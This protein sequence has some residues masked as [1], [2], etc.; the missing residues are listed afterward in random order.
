MTRTRERASNHRMDGDAINLAR[1]A[2]RSPGKKLTITSVAEFIRLR[3]SE[4]PAEYYRAAHEDAPLEVWEGVVHTRPDMRFWVAHNKTVPIAILTLLSEDP[5]SDV[6]GMVARKRKI[7]EALQLKLAADSDDSVRHSLA[8]NAKATEKVLS[9]LAEDSEEYVREAA[10]SRMPSR[11]KG[12][13]T[14]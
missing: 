10:L 6:R 2:D 12:G 9:I 1:H 8:F 14:S 13:E 3:E 4:D 5:S 11:A 7:P